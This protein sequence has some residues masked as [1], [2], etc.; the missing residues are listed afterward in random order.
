MDGGRSEVSYHRNTNSIEKMYIL[1]HCEG[2]D[3]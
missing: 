2:K 3:N 1:Q